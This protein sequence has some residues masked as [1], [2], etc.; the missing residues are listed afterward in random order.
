MVSVLHGRIKRF[1]LFFGVAS[2]AAFI[3]NV[4]SQF[5]INNGVI[6]LK[7]SIIL[8]ITLGIVLAII[9]AAQHTVK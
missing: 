5:L 1:W 8:S 6:D 3:A 4:S 9:M 2:I 7:N